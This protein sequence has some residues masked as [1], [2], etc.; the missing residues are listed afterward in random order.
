MLCEKLLQEK[1]SVDN[2]DAEKYINMIENAEEYI[3]ANE[4]LYQSIIENK[5]LKGG[6]KVKKGIKALIYVASS[7][8]LFL[9]LMLFDYLLFKKIDLVAD[10]IIT[11]IFTVGNILGAKKFIDDKDADKYTKKQ[12]FNHI[13]ITVAIMVVALFWYYSI[14]EI[15]VVN[16][17]PNKNVL[18]ISVKNHL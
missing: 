13:L 14:K 3:F 7:I 12:K 10:L 5:N 2:I 11:A 1:S 8:L 18:E 6:D 17:E 9:L 15:N 16:Q 4:K